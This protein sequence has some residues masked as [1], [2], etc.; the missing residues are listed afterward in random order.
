MRY[1][2][3]YFRFYTSSIFLWNKIG[4]KKKNFYILIYFYLMFTVF[5]FSFL[6]YIKIYLVKKNKSEKVIST[7]RPCLKSTIEWDSIPV[8]IH[9]NHLVIWVYHKRKG[10]NQVEF[11]RRIIVFYFSCFVCDEFFGGNHFPSSKCYTK[12]EN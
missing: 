8:L 1:N 2:E 10:R 5:T 11:P 3:N 7:L 6:F 9:R 12:H 4:K